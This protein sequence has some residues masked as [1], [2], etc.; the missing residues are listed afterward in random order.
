MLQ[1]IGR[2]VS[3]SSQTTTTSLS[4]GTQTVDYANAWRGGLGDGFAKGM[5]RIS[6]YFLRLAEKILPVLEVDAGSPV[7]IVVSQGVRLSD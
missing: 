1:G 6:A 5:D 7:D 4:S 3:L 2:A